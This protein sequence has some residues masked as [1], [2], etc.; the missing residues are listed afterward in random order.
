M[1]LFARILALPHYLMIVE[2]FRC[3]RETTTGTSSFPGGEEGVPV[4]WCDVASGRQT[5]AFNP[6]GD[7]V[8]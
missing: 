8:G 6:V 5:G 3:I 1:H 7:Q 4:A 2:I